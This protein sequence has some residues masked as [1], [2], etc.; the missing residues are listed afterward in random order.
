MLEALGAPYRL[1]AHG[2]LVAE[3]AEVL[4]L[5][6]RQV[7]FVVDESWVL[8]GAVLHDAGKIVHP[9]ELDAPGKSHESAGEALLLAHGVERHVAHTCVSHAAWE[10]ASCSVEE[11][12]VALADALWKGVRRPVLETAIIDEVARRTQADRWSIFVDLDTCF[13][14]IADEGSDRLARSQAPAFSSLPR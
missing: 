9:S 10:H 2:L 1:I 7:G 11:K 12:L 14:A 8:A 3:A 13:E 6:L 4:L 5:K